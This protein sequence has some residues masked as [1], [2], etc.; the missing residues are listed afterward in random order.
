MKSPLDPSLERAILFF[1]ERGC[2]HCAGAKKELAAMAGDFQSREI[3]LIELDVE[4]DA[5]LV[6]RFGLTGA[7]SF[8]FLAFGNPLGK[9]T[10]FPGRD[11]F[12]RAIATAY[13]ALA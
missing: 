12:L 3:D 13:S 7:P 1:A 10:G 11:G 6:K 2:P 9:I 4:Y 5:D 8:V